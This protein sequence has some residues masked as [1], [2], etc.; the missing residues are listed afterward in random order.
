MSKLP[1]PEE[2]EF[3]DENGQEWERVPS[4][5]TWPINDSNVRVHVFR[6]KPKSAE[7]AIS[8]LQVIQIMGGA[9][10]RECSIRLT[11]L[12]KL[13]LDLAVETARRIIREEM[14]K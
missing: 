12:L 11:Q 5:T 9:L 13:N 6:P 8:E 7:P 3:V 14:K 1:K 10:S 4:G 2:L